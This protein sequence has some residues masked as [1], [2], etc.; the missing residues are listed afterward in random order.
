MIVCDIWGGHLHQ[1]HVARYILP[2]EDALIWAK[3][4]LADGYLVNLRDD[5]EISGFENFETRAQ[6]PITTDGGSH[7]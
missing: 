1:D 5:A 4:E 2:V 3:Q 6:S 7:R